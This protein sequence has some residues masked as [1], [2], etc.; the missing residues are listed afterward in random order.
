MKDFQF[1]IFFCATISEMKLIGELIWIFAFVSTA[2][3]VLSQALPSNALPTGGMIQAGEAHIDISSKYVDSSVDS[4]CSCRL[5]SFNVEG[6][7]GI[8]TS[9]ILP[10][11]L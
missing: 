4:S 8:L 5:N 2:P 11:L 6:C 10:L 3:A 1:E 7:I 9:P